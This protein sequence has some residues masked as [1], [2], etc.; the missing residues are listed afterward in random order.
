MNFIKSTR[1]LSIL[2]AASIV[3]M[4]NYV[5]AANKTALHETDTKAAV[6]NETD[7]PLEVG[8]LVTGTVL[9]LGTVE[10]ASVN[11]RNNPNLDADIV[12]V[13]EKGQQTAVLSKDGD[14][15]RI[16]ADGI[17]GFVSAEYMTVASE[18]QA[19]LGYAL[20][21]CAAAN[22]R[23]SADTESDPVAS[24]E[25]GEVVSIVGVSD[26]WYQVNIDGTTGYI[27]SDLVDS[28]AEVPAEMVYDYVVIKC[29]AAN[30]R[31]A[32]DASSE[33]ID[34]L[35]QGSLCQLLAQEG[36]WY[37]VQYGDSVGYINASLTAETNDAAD[38][39]ANLETYNDVV[40]RQAAEAA[41]EAAA[42]AAAAAQ[43]TSN[44]NSGSAA[45]GP[46]S[47]VSSSSGSSGSAASSNS[48]STPAALSYNAGSS[49]SI[50]SVAQNYLGVPYVWGGTSPSGFD[51]S[52]FTQYVLRQCGYNINRTAAAQYSNG[53]Y[54]SYGSLQAGDLVFFA[55]TY[56]ASGITHVGIYIGGGQFIHAASGGVKISSLSESYY[57]SRYY[58]A[59]RIA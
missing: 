44:S 47:S 54:V 53:S 16:S 24:L 39:S 30:L 7:I 51:C 4:P 28:T 33:K 22:V 26:G 18:G 5:M 20:I 11:V 42:A 55:N 25:E 14:W 1:A 40:E 52:G 8:D 17:T 12:G 3:M 35:Y 13:L 34:M 48:V 57:S 9:G 59:R 50:V 38:G 23:V 37:K 15:Y 46:S 45:S 43:N 31:S 19:D 56:A 21:K 58:G 10:G 27:R 6:L 32:S 2:M 49:S 36:D 41:A 29:A